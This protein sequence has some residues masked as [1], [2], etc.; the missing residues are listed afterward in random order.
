MKIRSVALG[1][2]MTI[3]AS[4]ALIGGARAAT[5]A[6]P[7]IPVWSF[8]GGFCPTCADTIVER[9]RAITV[10][11]LR[12]RYAEA[13]SDFGGYRIYRV[14]N[15][16]DTASMQLIR[17]Y[18]VQPS[19][20]FLWYFSR[21]DTSDAMLPF[22]NNGVLATDSV[23]TFV[24]PDSTGHYEKVCRFV[25]RFGRC[26]TRGDSIMV[27]VPP[28]GP[29]DGFRTYYAVTYEARNSSADAGYADTYVAG[30]DTFNN[31][32]R[33]GTPGD[34]STCPIINLNNKALNVTPLQSQPLLEPTA[35]PA[36]NLEQVKVVPNPYRATEAWDATGANEIHFTHLPAQAKIQIFTVSGD[37]VAEIHHADDIRD[38]ARW[39]LRNQNGQEVSSGIYM[40][41]IQAGSF[42]YRNRFIVIR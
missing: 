10:R 6:F 4:V 33:C 28:P 29:H 40:Y 9:P 8:A 24:D 17:R 1:C 2:L 39:D 3:V 7:R 19:D 37:L 20:Q 12:D 41:R 36:A 25:D 21:V 23:I 31:F 18:S 32:A 26:L 13:R 35:G 5:S 34:T 16:P 27:L 30:R 11:F 38:F 42:E 15:S 22:K 14:T